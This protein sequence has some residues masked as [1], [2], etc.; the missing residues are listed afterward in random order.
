MPVQKK[1]TTYLKFLAKQ[2]AGYAYSAQQ[3]A[4]H[5]K[6]SSSMDKK[7]QLDA[8]YARYKS[9]TQCP[10]ATQGRSQVV[11]G[12]GNSNAQLMFVGEAPGKDEDMQGFPF[13][14]RAGQ[15]LTK[16]IEA[17]GIQR[18]EVYISNIVKCRPPENRTPLPIERTT[19][20]ELLLFKEIEIINPVIICTLGAP[21]TQGLLGDS[22]KISEAR[23]IIH[24]FKTYPVLP[25][26]HPAYLLRNP[27]EKKTVW[28]DMQKIMV[29]LKE[30]T[31]NQ[32]K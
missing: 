26:Y 14:G 13:I 17:M 4:S 6:A 28:E 25:T 1:L 10:L 15:L 8:L 3:P 22:I 23:G 2:P 7:E 20:K 21:A 27:S 24:Y 32:Q 11:F 9:C 18:E 29:F 30:H 19:C 5:Q 16:I 12:T 31:N